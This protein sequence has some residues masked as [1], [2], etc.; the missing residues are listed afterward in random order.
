MSTDL[1]IEIL[2]FT[3]RRSTDF[4]EDVAST[5]R[6]VFLKLLRGRTICHC[7][8]MVGP[9]LKSQVLFEQNEELKRNLE[10]PFVD[11]VQFTKR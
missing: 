9:Q 11:S 1:I 3:T 6:S 4:V 5:N 10:R 8:S 2:Y 7:R